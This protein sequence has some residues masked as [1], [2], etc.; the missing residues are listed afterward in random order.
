MG[1]PVGSGADVVT[2]GGGKGIEQPAHGGLGV[3]Q[4]LGVPLHAD[5]EGTAGRLDALD[6]AVGGEGAGPQAGGQPLDGLVVHAVDG[7]FLGGEDCRQARVGLDAHGMGQ[8]VA[9]EGVGGGEV[10][11]LDGRGALGGDVLVEAAA[12]GD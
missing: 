2:D 10:V 9:G 1:N 12:A 11:V 8:V 4:L 3:G 5:G 7:Q 6:Q